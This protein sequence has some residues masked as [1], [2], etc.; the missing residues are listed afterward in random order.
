MTQKLAL[1]VVMIK[2]LGWFGEV[3]SKPKIE[4]ICYNYTQEGCVR[5][6]KAATV[7]SPARNAKWVV[8]KSGKGGRC[9]YKE[10]LEE[11]THHSNV[12]K[13]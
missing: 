3:S 11:D 8:N 13:F 7:T 4:N 9:C 10:T 1:S 5:L 2:G 12:F 6:K